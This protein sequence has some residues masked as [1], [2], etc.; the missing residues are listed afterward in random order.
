MK[1]KVFKK[2][3]LVLAAVMLLSVML[4]VPAAA[5]DTV[6]F[7]F[8]PYYGVD[9]DLNANYSEGVTGGVPDDLIM[10]AVEMNSGSTPICYTKI[11]VSWDPSKLSLIFTSNTTDLMGVY[12]GRTST[13]DGLVN[14][15]VAGTRIANKAS[16]QNW[17]YT[18]GFPPASHNIT[19]AG[20]F[21]L[22]FEPVSAEAANATITFNEV[23]AQTVPEVGGSYYL[24]T[25]TTDITLKLNGGVEVADPI[26]SLG[27]KVNV[28]ARG[29]RFG[30]EFNKTEGEVEEMGMLLFPT[31]RLAG[32]TL[33]MDYY[34]ANPYSAGNPTGVLKIQ[35][36]G[37]R[38]SD[39]VPGQAFGMYDT[40]VFFITLNNVPVD[41]GATDV[42]AVPF[43][44][45]A[46]GTIEYGD[47]LV[48][49][50]DGVVA[51]SDAIDG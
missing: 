21:F 2:L 25:A 5:D 7:S 31:H 30:A 37:I 18:E 28:A 8:N 12:T 51:A 33:D 13:A 9:G 44:K 39:F 23:Y 27:A 45:Y 43:I 49:N 41:E 36:T 11:N 40:F 16:A 20:I 46:D 17:T 32:A 48:R 6:Q 14:D 10:V 35:S 29:M 50:Y 19:E 26:V 3:S 34:N 38:A 4:V 22:Y 24:E 1:T 42:T 47:A 15:T